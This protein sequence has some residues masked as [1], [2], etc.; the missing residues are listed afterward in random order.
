MQPYALT[1]DKFLDHAAK[2]HPTAEVVT[3]GDHPS[4]ISYAALRETSNHLS[5]AFS[6]MG[7][8]TGD[9]IATLAWNTEGHMAAWYA[10]IA[11]G[12]VCHTL[13]PRLPVAHI[14]AMVD[15]AEDQILAFGVGL[16]PLAAE[17]AAQCPTI[18]CL[19]ALDEPECAIEA[20]QVQAERW[21]LK[22]LIDKL[23]APAEWGA[24][25]ETAPSGLC[26][27]SGTT[28][29]PKGVLYDH[30]SGYLHTLRMLQADALGLR[31][32]DTILAAVPMFHANGWGLP[33]AAPAVGATLVLPGRDTSGP[34]LAKLIAEEKVTAVA[35]VPTVWL[36]LLDHLDAIGQSLP[37]LKRLFLGGA[38]MPQ[39]VQKRIEAR[40]DIT[41]HTSWGMTELSPLGTL[42]PYGTQGTPPGTS[43]RSAIG[44]DMRLVDGD[45]KPLTEQRNVEGRLMVKGHSVVDRYFGEDDPATDAEGWFDTGDLAV[46]DSDGNLSITGRAKDLIKSGGEWINPSEIENIAGAIPGISLAAVIG[47]ADD[48]WGERPVLIIQPVASM[49]LSD[50]QVIEALRGRIASWWMPDAV[51][52]IAQM[53][54]AATGKIDKQR[55]R[56]LYA[57]P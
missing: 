25:D 17:I 5:G 20:S 30:R 42:S 24:F 43:G 27:T 14:T 46:I 3:G 7:L 39:A 9:R 36:G 52:R 2:W 10:A 35:G 49:S 1:L 29:A 22:T 44:V 48:K 37:S 18:R 23:G 53:P 55:L 56:A 26:F 41:V 6:K 38:P 57:Q 40:L 16:A 21:S 31:R 34:A 45:G 33:F 54:L 11:S 32:E 13:N 28:G 51:I 4:R 8:R 19:I 50:E 15:K 12:I 47:R